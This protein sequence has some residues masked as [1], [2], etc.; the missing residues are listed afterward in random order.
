MLIKVL[1]KIHLAIIY[2]LNHFIIL[3]CDLLFICNFCICFLY[4]CHL[5][6]F[7]QFVLL[8]KHVTSTS[9]IGQSALVLSSGLDDV[10]S[11]RYANSIQESCQH[12]EQLTTQLHTS[13]SDGRCKKC[14]NKLRLILIIYDTTRTLSHS[15]GKIIILRIVCLAT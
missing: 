10:D 15:N 3:L 14:Q 5:V 6:F 4:M 8:H 11:C 12:L 9:E 7:F 13:T 2:I 1:I